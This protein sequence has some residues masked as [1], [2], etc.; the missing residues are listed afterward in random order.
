[1]RSVKVAATGAMAMT[2]PIRRCLSIGVLLWTAGLTVTVSAPHAETASKPAIS[3]AVTAAIAQMGRSLQAEQFSFRARTLRVYAGPNGRPLHIVHSMKITVR[4]PDR[5]LVDVTGDDGSTKLFY[6]GKLVTLL[7][8]ETNKYETSPALD[9]IQGMLDAITDRL[10]VDFPLADFLNN[11]PDKSVLLGVTSG[12]EVNTVM[13]D[14]VPCRHLLLTEPPG[15]EVELWLEKNDR[16]LPR[17]V[18]IT[19]RTM[20]GQPSVVAELSGWDFSGHPSDEEFVF[21]P[22]KDAVRVELK[23]VTTG[24]PAKPRGAK[25]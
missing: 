13:I 16:A 7:G 5:L 2:N 11:A 14:G 17:R 3:E 25:P 1:M 9:T 19:Y 18:I 6:D 15:V 24:A 8:V 20:S 10:G 21:Q 12:E 4:R 22:P 23:P